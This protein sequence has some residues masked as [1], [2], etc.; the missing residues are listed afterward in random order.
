[1]VVSDMARVELLA[2]LPTTDPEGV[3]QEAGSGWDG[4]GSGWDWMG[5]HGWDQGA[6]RNVSSSRY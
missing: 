6:W 4:F 3:R 1:M 2:R 5:G